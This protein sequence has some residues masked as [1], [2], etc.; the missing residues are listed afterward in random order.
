MHPYLKELCDPA[1]VAAM[2]G[3]HGDH[4]ILQEGGQHRSQVFLPCMIIMLIVLLSTRTHWSTCNASHL[5][6]CPHVTETCNG[7]IIS[8]SGRS[9]S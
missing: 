9:N 1:P 2:L 6:T 4:D 5:H 8:L 3:M 7:N